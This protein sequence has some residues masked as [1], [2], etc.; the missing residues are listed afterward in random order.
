M[1]YYDLKMTKRYFLHTNIGKP[2]HFIIS[3]HSAQPF[4]RNAEQFWLINRETDR[5]TNVSKS[6]NIS[7]KKHFTAQSDAEKLIIL[8][9]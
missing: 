3:F 6:L 8:L 7:V 4:L 1:T 5:Q 2:F 9:I